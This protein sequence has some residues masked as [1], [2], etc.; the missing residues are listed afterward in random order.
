MCLKTVSSTVVQFHQVV[1]EICAYE[2]HEQSIM[3]NVLR[4]KGAEGSKVPDMQTGLLFPCAICFARVFLSIGSH[5]LPFFLEVTVA[6]PLCGLLGSYCSAS[7]CWGIFRGCCHQLK[8][9]FVEG[10][11]LRVLWGFGPASTCCLW[12]IPYFH[13]RKGRLPLRC[14]CT[15]RSAVVS[16][17][18]SK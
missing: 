3:V 16:N 10:C 11:S 12:A 7:Q 8:K 13:L 4:L 5:V 14:A 6:P 1:R 9:T 17:N 2:T 18:H 15:S